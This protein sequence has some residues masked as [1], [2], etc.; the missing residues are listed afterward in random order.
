MLTTTNE[1]A[2]LESVIEHGLKTFYEVGA[3]LLTIRDKKLYKAH[4]KT[5]EA[6]CQSR[7]DMSRPRSYQLMDAAS[8]YSHLST[9][10]DTPPTNERQARELAPL[11]P[12]E[13]GIVWS[14][15]EQTAPGGSVTAA[16]IKSVVTV[17]RE[18]M[19][20]GAL[21]DGTGNQIKVSDIARAQIV[22]ET[23][24]R[25]QR[26]TG[27]IVTKQSQTPPDK[28]NRA[29]KMVEGFST[30]EVPAD[31]R[32]ETALTA[33]KIAAALTLWADRLEAA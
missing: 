28:L 9:I 3:A 12:D 5:F 33:R 4:H 27:Y 23:Y 29:I 31:Q 13:Q 24:E 32:H 20:T 11:T 1:L 16:H 18:V 6:Y 26:Q 14:V 21:D 22:E 8:V 10:V 17:F 30:L 2:Q 19:V 15:V 7:W 25:M